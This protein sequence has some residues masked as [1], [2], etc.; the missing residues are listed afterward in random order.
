MGRSLLCRSIGRQL[1]LLIE[2]VFLWY[3]NQLFYN[4]PCKIGTIMTNKDFYGRHS[5]F[6]TLG[7][8][9]LIAIF[10]FGGYCHV[11]SFYFLRYKSIVS[12]I[13]LFRIIIDSVSITWPSGCHCNS[14]SGWIKASEWRTFGVK[15]SINV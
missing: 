10:E 6:C 15:P 2:I 1:S 11:F 7:T 3:E 13:K 9:R 5:L 4:R 12:T 14:V 8:S